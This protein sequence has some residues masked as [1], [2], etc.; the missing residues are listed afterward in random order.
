MSLDKFSPNQIEQIANVLQ[1]AASHA[2]LDEE[3]PPQAARL[4]GVL[5][6]L[7]LGRLLGSWIS[8]GQRQ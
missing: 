2:D 3:D 7:F 1:G 5:R 8:H 4:L 6:V